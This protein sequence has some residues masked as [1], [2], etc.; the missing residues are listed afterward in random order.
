[1]AIR[2]NLVIGST[3]E[4]QQR[5]QKRLRLENQFGFKADDDGSKSPTFEMLS[6]FI[7]DIQEMKVHLGLLVADFATKQEPGGGCVGIPQGPCRMYRSHSCTPWPRTG[8]V[9][10]FDTTSTA[11]SD[12]DGSQLP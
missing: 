8:H 4:Q 6:T 3:I 1:M 9:D 2:S 12:Y 5:R 11:C 10:D 7:Q